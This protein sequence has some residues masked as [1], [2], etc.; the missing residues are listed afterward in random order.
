MFHAKCVCA[1]HVALNCSCC[2]REAWAPSVHKLHT[3]AASNSRDHPM[4]SLFIVIWLI[5]PHANIRT[6]VRLAQKQ[7]RPHANM[8]LPGSL[9]HCLLASRI[10]G[11][12]SSPSAYA[13]GGFGVNPPLRFI[14]SKT[15]ITYAK[16]IN[17]LCKLFAC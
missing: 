9:Y 4:R 12:Y 11:C 6:T 15:F 8:T 7:L 5:I 10:Y 2:D 1:E 13:S 17:C 16:E 3:V 14:F